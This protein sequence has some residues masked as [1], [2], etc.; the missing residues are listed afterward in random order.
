MANLHPGRHGGRRRGARTPEI[1]D[2]AGTF[3]LLPGVA[4]ARLHWWYPRNWVAPD[5]RIFGY[6]DLTMYYVDPDANAA[7]ARLHQAG[8]MPADGP[9]GVT[10]S[11]VM[12]APG[13]I[14]RV[15]G[16]AASSRRPR[17]AKKAAVVIDINGATPWSPRPRPCR[18]G[19][20]GTPPR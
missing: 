7:P 4:T 3:R 13:K 9:S 14:L 12:Y 18:S 1:R 19:C 2:A 17:P 10:S 16:G 20:T 6:A 5:G 11:E 15:G 8:T